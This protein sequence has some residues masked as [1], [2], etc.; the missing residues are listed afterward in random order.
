V[1]FQNAPPRRLQHSMQTPTSN[2][3]RSFTFCIGASIAP[4]VAISPASSNYQL[5][6]RAPALPTAS[7]TCA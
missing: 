1:R 7:T 4:M 5:R 6:S 3:L 2:N